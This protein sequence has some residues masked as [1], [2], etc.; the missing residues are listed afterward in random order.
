MDGKCSSSRDASS[1][2]ALDARAQLGREARG[3]SDF[4]QQALPVR[5][6]QARVRKIGRPSL[7][8]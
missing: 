6:R 3:R 4:E 1:N 7:L 5:S 2:E 8:S